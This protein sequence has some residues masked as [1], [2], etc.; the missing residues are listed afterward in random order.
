VRNQHPAQQTVLHMAPASPEVLAAGRVAVRSDAAYSS[1]FLIGQSIARSF[2]MDGEYLRVTQRLRVGLGQNLEAELQLPFAH[3]SG[4]FLDAFI[5][6]Y[7]DWF[8]FPDQARSENPRNDFEI[9][10]LRNGATVWSVDADSFEWLDV[11]LQLTWQ[12]MPSG[13]ERFGLAARSALELPIGDDR[14]GYGNGEIDFAGG[15]IADWRPGAVTLYGHLQHT[16]AG[17]PRQSRRA[18]FA[19]ADVTSAGLAAELPLLPDLAALVQVEWETSTLRNL[20]LPTAAR[21]QVLL[22][23]GARWQPHRDWAFEVGLGE[24][25]QGLVSP[26]FT[27][28]LGFAWTPRNAGLERR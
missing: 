18:D 21:D 7:H 16:F 22:W 13:P 6:D 10:A 9:G 23:V 19:F 5:I 28:W 14:R 1:L 26:D 25:L 4:G 27:A 20:G 12:C 15:L 17:T 8:G 24:D 3:T 2:V 11:P